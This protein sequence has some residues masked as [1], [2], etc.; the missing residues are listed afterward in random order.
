[1]AVNVGVPS[2]SR[3]RIVGITNSGSWSQE[4]HV[5]PL[6]KEMINWMG[7]GSQVNNVVGTY[8]TDPSSEASSITVDMYY[9]DGSGKKPSNMVVTK[10]DAPGLEGY[11]I[12]GQD[13]GGR[14]AGPAFWN[15]MALIYW[16][17]GY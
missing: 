14:P 4:I 1:M 5:Q 7:T 16:A 3:V 11:V 13:A 9:N 12:G 8:V 6:G 15:T 10:F 2:N 17:K